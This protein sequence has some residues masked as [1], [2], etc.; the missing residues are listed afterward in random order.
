MKVLPT[1]LMIVL[2]ASFSLATAGCS[3]KPSEYSVMLE[4]YGKSPPTGI[5]DPR[6]EAARAAKWAGNWR[7][8]LAFFKGELD[9]G[10]PVR[11][12]ATINSLALLAAAAE[13]A[14]GL[15]DSPSEKAQF[16]KEFPVAKLKKILGEHPDY[17]PWFV[18]YSGTPFGA[19]F[20]LPAAPTN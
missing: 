7:A 11:V 4:V 8:S 2:G 10:D 5:A 16:T 6:V 1:L 17:A 14:A 20:P 15:A 3:R 19:E 12:R 13:Q 18:F 9:S